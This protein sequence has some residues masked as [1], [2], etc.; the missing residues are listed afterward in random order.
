MGKLRRLSLLVLGASIALPLVAGSLG[1]ATYERCVQGYRNTQS[2]AYR[3]RLRKAAAECVGWEEKLRRDPRYRGNDRALEDAM[4][5]HPCLGGPPVCRERLGINETRDECGEVSS[6][7][8]G[9]SA[10]AREA[11]RIHD[12]LMAP[13]IT[14]LC[15]F[16]Q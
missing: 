9:T 12:E 14:E 2:A 16:A 11:N 10:Q 4:Y 15:T 5:R 6:R 7:K 13:R 8:L 1:A 3:E